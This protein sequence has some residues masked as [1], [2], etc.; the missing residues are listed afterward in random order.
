MAEKDATSNS[1]YVTPFLHPAPRHLRYDGGGM[2]HA[3]TGA[4][5]QLSVQPVD[6]SVEPGG[7]A[8]QVA[9]HIANLTSE[10]LDIR[11]VW[12]PHSRFWS[13][14]CALHPALPVPA[15]DRALLRQRVRSDAASGE[16]VE[17]AFL[18]LTVYWGGHPWRVLARM[19][20]ERSAAGCVGLVVEAITTHRVGFAR[21]LADDG[22]AAPG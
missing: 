2:S 22:A 12:L 13:E 18:H 5:P 8:V 21:A 19:R 7:G 9:W 16:V 20:V 17:N 11:E 1:P 14:R 6:V 10:P 4:A 3:I 15:G